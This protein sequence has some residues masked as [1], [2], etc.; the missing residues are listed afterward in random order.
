MSVVWL[1]SY[2]SIPILASTPVTLGSSLSPSQ[3]T[4]LGGVDSN[5]SLDG[6]GVRTAKQSAAFSSKIALCSG[7]GV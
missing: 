5:L 3:S 1:V 2:P 7:M 6:R 4:E